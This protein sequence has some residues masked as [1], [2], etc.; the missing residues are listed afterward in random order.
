MSMDILAR[1]DR[2][3]ISLAKSAPAQQSQSG[4][5]AREDQ[6]MSDTA[7]LFGALLE[8]PQSKEAG[9]S[10]QKDDGDPQ[11]ADAVSADPLLQSYVCTVPQ[12]LFSLAANLSV[13]HETNSPLPVG[14]DSQPAVVP[15]ANEADPTSLAPDAA[16]FALST[17]IENKPLGLTTV[18]K[19]QA[20]PI[21]TKTGN[22]TEA[23]L[24]NSVLKQGNAPP[25][26]ANM[27]EEAAIVKRPAE[28]VNVQDRIVI[29][30]PPQISRGNGPI[31]A[32]VEIVAQQ[33]SAR[34]DDIQL[35]SERSFGAV[36]TLHIKLDPVELGTVTARIRVEVDTIEV[37]LIAD[38]AH[39]AEALV[40][41]RAM[42]EKALK[43]A[44][45]TE[46]AKITVTV[47]ERGALTLQQTTSSQS[48]GHQQTG[49][50]LSGQQQGSGMQSDADGRN[51]SQGQSQSHFMGGE[52]RQNGESAHTRR[53]PSD[54]RRPNAEA[55]L[56]ATAHNNGRHRGLV[57]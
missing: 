28:G 4:G 18:D 31:E 1:A 48:A 45:V 26:R 39:G 49:N 36:K 30:P 19:R 23:V 29:Q 22:G 20:A 2:R 16:L 7:K 56:D 44:G 43:A 9:T 55:I 17:D 21:N 34:I 25:E 6:Q 5:Q 41:D 14:A 51:G 40:A 57:V 11:E 33:A 3:L 27:A 35:I 24:E 52:S 54:A 47:A 53:G 15:D 12:R 42:I 46:D 10:A 8:K 13:A 50:Q 32:K 38:K 37:H